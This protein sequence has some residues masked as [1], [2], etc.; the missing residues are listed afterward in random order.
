MNWRILL[1]AGLIAVFAIIGLY[2]GLIMS[3]YRFSLSSHASTH[4]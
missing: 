2:K 1:L 3:V 4:L